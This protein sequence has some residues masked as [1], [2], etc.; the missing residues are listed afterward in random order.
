MLN[1]N[2]KFIWSLANKPKHAKTRMSLFTV[3]I[4]V[5]IKSINSR[6]GCSQPT[7]AT[8][9]VSANRLAPPPCNSTLPADT[10]RSSP[11]S[12]SSDV[13]EQISLGRCRERLNTRRGECH[14]FGDFQEV[15]MYSAALWLLRSISAGSQFHAV[16]CFSAR[17]DLRHTCRNWDFHFFWDFGCQSV[18]L[19][20]T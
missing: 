6:S 9:W 18:L 13:R 10:Q 3:S 5:M 2:I 1:N 11:A 7:G 8:H 12:G 20:C 4:I 19:Y 17:S 16:Y 14:C 15:F